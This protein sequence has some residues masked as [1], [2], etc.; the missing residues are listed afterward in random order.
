LKKAIQQHL[1]LPTD[2]DCKKGVIWIGFVVSSNGSLSMVTVDFPDKK[3][4][5]QLEQ[6]IRK[7][8]YWPPAH[9]ENDPVSVYMYTYL[10]LDEE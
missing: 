4:K 2:C 3:V 5:I 10:L 8:A 6:A 7:L 1:E 9:L